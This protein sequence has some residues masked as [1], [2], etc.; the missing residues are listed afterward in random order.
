M[1]A[2]ELRSAHANKLSP[3]DLDSFKES[4]FPG[5]VTAYNTPWTNKAQR[6]PIR[7][8]EE[9]GVSPKTFQALKILFPYL[10]TIFRA[11]GARF[12]PQL[13]STVA[14]HL[15][16][17]N[18]LC[19][20]IF[21][22]EVKERVPTEL[23]EKF[24]AMEKHVRLSLMLHD[25]AEIP[26]EISTFC[27][28]LPKTDA[29]VTETDRQKLENRV[30]ELLIYYALKAVHEGNSSL[31]REVNEA[32]IESQ[33]RTKETTESAEK[34]FKIVETFAKKIETDTSEFSSAEF[35]KDFQQLKDSYYISEGSCE[36][37]NQETVVGSFT[38]L[39]DK[40]ESKLH[41]AIV[42]DY[43][44]FD[45]EPSKIIEKEF[46]QAQDFISSYTQ[47]KLIRPALDKV[48]ELYEASV[49]IFR[50]WDKLKEPLQAF[51]QW[52][53]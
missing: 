35:Q 8:H 22:K 11:T 42:G 7:S 20:D 25:L 46:N 44:I 12:I 34:R 16:G 49:R 2:I 30:A 18:N 10:D 50:E 9:L 37:E 48:I 43:S 4:V 15:N 31:P 51:Q 45:M 29:S 40:L 14:N 6:F 41:C 13:H 33:Q 36:F 23:Q 24:A 26:G 27:Q 28:R 47:D 32:I 3:R 53:S 39:I 52:L 21:G 38:K 5:N 17:L 19:N 1:V